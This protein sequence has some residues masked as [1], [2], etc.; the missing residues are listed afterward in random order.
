MGIIFVAI[1]TA[2]LS[3]IYNSEQEEETRKTFVKHMDTLR[4]KNNLTKVQISEL[5]DRLYKLEHENRDLTY[6]LESLNEK[7]DT[8]LEKMD[9]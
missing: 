9:E 2:Y 8:I 4:V 6:Q 3:A 7:V 1:F 5:N